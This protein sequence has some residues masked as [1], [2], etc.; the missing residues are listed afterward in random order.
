MNAPEW[1]GRDAFE[2][3]FLQPFI[4]L[5]LPLLLLP[6]IIHLINRLRHRPQP[7]AAMMFLIAATRSSTSQ[8]KLR[9]WLVLLFRVLA[10]AA[11]I[12]FLARPLTGGWLGWAVNRAP[13]VILIVLDRSASM[14]TKLPGQTISKR[15]HALKLLT[16]AAAEFAENS[17]IVL[18]DNAI[19][20]PQQ[21]AS[22]KALL[23]ESLTGPTDTAADLPALL[24]IAQKWLTDNQAG[25]SEIWIASDL[26]R[27][28]WQPDDDRWEALVAQ[29]EEMPQPVRFRLLT[30]G[31]E[32]PLNRSVSLAQMQLDS[33][34]EADVQLSLDLKSSEPSEKPFPV[35]VRTSESES[36]NDVSL[37]GA[38]LRWQHRLKLRDLAEAPWGA[39][40]IPDDAN[41]RDNEVFFLNRMPDAASAVVVSDSP[42]GSK[43]LRFAALSSRGNRPAEVV[44]PARFAETS[45]SDVSLIIWQAA[46]PAEQ[47]RLKSYLEE[48]GVVV[49]LPSDGTNHA[50]FF[51]TT[52]AGLEGATEDSNFI[53]QQWNEAEGPLARTDEGMSLPLGSLE[54][55]KRQLIDGTSSTLASFAD[56]RPLLTRGTHGRGNYFFCATLPHR[57]WS[58]LEDGGVLVP[59]IQRLL[60]QGTR[61][62]NRETMIAAGELSPIDRN[63]VWRSLD[64]TE[65]KNIRLHAGVYRSGDRLLAVNRSAAE[66]DAELVEP[67][68]AVKLFGD[69]PVQ[70]SEQTDVDAASLQG[71][72]WRMFLAGMLIFLITESWLVLPPAPR[73]KEPFES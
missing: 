6:V 65:L 67:S 53:V 45:L 50:S 47:G 33:E 23:Q 26:Q 5:G 58:N 31:T 9:Q 35:R 64:S 54:I 46:I 73:S 70:W 15:E 36:H 8:A 2:M 52:W 38:S 11:L 30:F 72:A 18:L 48:G 42:E 17:H 25:A 32:Q 10:V 40:S 56:G 69:L 24:Q 49:F 7:W 61:R 59:M 34:T 22:A 51:N 66:D 4:L 1:R 16:E 28:N 13:D 37:R 68:A 20:E 62:L 21:L 29:F 19:R 63:R 71:E 27:S 41:S 14:E 39:A 57:D 12:F 44:A 60:E 3:T 43:F 55:R